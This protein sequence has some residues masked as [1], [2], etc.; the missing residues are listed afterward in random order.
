VTQGTNH[1]KGGVSV[2]ECPKKEKKPPGRV[3]RRLCNI[4]RV[5]RN[6][7]KKGWE[8]TP[9]SYGKNRVVVNRIL[10]SSFAPWYSASATLFGIMGVKEIK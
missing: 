2:R 10:K 4:A 6:K 9:K 5:K 7:K 1:S 8:K 3:G